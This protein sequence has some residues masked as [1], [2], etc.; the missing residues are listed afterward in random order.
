[1]GEVPGMITQQLLPVGTMVIS[2]NWEGCYSQCSLSLLTPH[3][4]CLACRS[5]RPRCHLPAS[6]ARA[7]SLEGHLFAAA[8]TALCSFEKHN[9]H[10]KLSLPDVSSTIAKA[11]DS[12]LQDTSGTALRCTPMDRR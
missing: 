6:A 5:S 9:L 11:F 10:L 4:S 2:Q 3:T 8:L 12:M 7:A 1:M